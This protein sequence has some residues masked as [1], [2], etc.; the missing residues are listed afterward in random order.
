MRVPEGP[1]VQLIFADGTV[2]SVIPQGEEAEELR[3]L[4]DNLLSRRDDGP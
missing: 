1:T 3:Y 2:E 4:V